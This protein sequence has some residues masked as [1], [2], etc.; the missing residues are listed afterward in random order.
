MKRDLP[1]IE[2]QG[3][4]RRYRGKGGVPVTALRDVS[5]Q[6]HAGEFAC[7]TGPSGSGKST[8][9]HILGCLDKPDSGSY[10]FAGREVQRLGPDGVAWLRRR[11]FG[12][13]FQN[14][15]LLGSATARENVEMPG[16]YAGLAPVP[17]RARALRLLEMLGLENR[18]EHRP[19][20]LSG[21]EQQRVSIARALMNGGRV[22]LADEPTG[23]LDTKNGEEVL[24]LLE[25]LAGRGHTVVLISHNP[26]V[27]A[28][29]K[30]RI[31]L[32]DG[33]VVADSGPVRRLQDE[34][35]D[36]ETQ[37][38]QQSAMGVIAHLLE[39]FRSGWTSL[40]ANLLRTRRVRAA[41]TVFS[42]LLGVWSVVTMLTIAEGAF[43]KTMAQVNRLGADRI[44][45]HPYTKGNDAPI[46]LTLE[47]ARVIASQLP[48]VRRILPSVT[49]Q[50]TARYGAKSVAI[51]VESY[52][53]IT[54][55]GNFDP[56]IPQVERGE[57]ITTRNNENRDQVVVIG[58]GIQ[59]Q[60]L[61]PDEDPLGQHIMIGTLPFL[62]KGVLAGRNAGAE[63]PVWFAPPA[64]RRVL[65]PFSTGAAFLYGTDKPQSLEVYVNE[66]RQIGATARAARELL[67]RRHGREGFRLG[68][69]EDRVEQ[70]GEVRTMLWLGLGSL[71][72]IALLAGGM[73]VMAIM[74][75]AVSE[76]TREI[77]I[78]MATGA[79]RRDI[80]QQFVIEAL[81]LAVV[82]GLLGLVAS[83]AT[84]P[85]VKLLDF[86]VAFSPWMVLVALA[87]AVGTGLVF[88]IVPAKRAARLDPV[89]ALAAQ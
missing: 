84:G 74:L 3:I 47:D 80:T 14:Y 75:M 8:L 30:R 82:G 83:V 1:L 61:P 23:A 27:A 79:R 63:L 39:G 13:V 36:E 20:A 2:L 35:W 58:W 81:A 28:R 56:E 54:P 6:L 18:F 76:R 41:L 52:A 12:F 89:A 5:L 77:G 44:E 26:E 72:G 70:A 22:I 32:L 29:A 34:H 87:C 88:G 17:R 50:M 51:R 31:E 73:G 60:L 65:I 67:I 68:Y 55:G 59:D 40:R 69:R 15:S 16:V 38:G 43:R 25:R 7:V 71:G 57:F 24:R 49:Q 21:G 11:A 10:R 64:S 33:R 19:A 53:P 86:P 48:N 78:R 4:V 62:V 42:M 66:P 85:L 46:T 37:A 45:I 9:L